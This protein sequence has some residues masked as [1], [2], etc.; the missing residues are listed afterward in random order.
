LFSILFL[1][2]HCNCSLLFCFLN[3]NNNKINCH[4]YLSN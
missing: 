2:S 4:S 3:N 1:L